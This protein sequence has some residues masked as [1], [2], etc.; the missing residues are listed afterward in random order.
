MN[1]LLSAYACEPNKG[2]EPG[3]G[4]SWA[5]SYA[6]KHRVW[7][8]T[9]ANNRSTIEEYLKRTPV[10]YIDNLRFIYVDLPRK[11]T[12]WKKGRRGMRLYYALWQKKAY[13]VACNLEKDITFDFVQHITFVSCTQ[14]TFMHRLH[15][16]FIWGPISGGE[17]IPKSIQYPL[18]I[19]EHCIEIIRR[20]SQKIAVNSSLF[21]EICLES[22]LIFSATEETRNMFPESIRSKIQILPAI[23]LD[24][25]LQRPIIHND[26]FKIV[27]AG[28]LIYWKA[29][30]IG[31]K[32]VVDLLDNEIPIELHILGEGPKKNDLEKMSGKYLNNAIFFDK[33][34]A[35]DNIYDYF[36]QFDLFLNTTLRDSGCMT[37]MEAAASGL[38]SIAIAIGG[39]KIQGNDYGAFL[40]QPKPMKSMVEEIKEAIISKMKA[41]EKNICSL[42]TVLTNYKTETVIRALKEDGK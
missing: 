21:R 17:N 42:E 33:A 7:V 23:G 31:I 36:A 3:V 19:K 18:S 20:L 4:W 35:H 39:P 10:D 38:P 37:M 26:I 25:V 1:I 34:V 28:R 16:P 8:I 5:L 12:W 13:E 29:F 2:S 6:K 27:M 9:K 30:D 22:R 40:I 14:P 32:A 15:A 11:Y 24:Y 41:N